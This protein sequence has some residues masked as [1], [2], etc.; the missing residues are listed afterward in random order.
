MV[1]IVLTDVAPPRA[2]S[3]IAPLMLRRTLATAARITLV[4]VIGL[5]LAASGASAKR[6]TLSS[7]RVSI[8][9]GAL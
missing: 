9:I 1:D 6:V 3:T 4:A 5:A 7:L 2:L 8:S